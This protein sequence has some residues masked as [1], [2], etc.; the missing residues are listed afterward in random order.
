PGVSARPERR[1]PEILLCTEGS[2][3]LSAGGESLA[4]PRG[5]SVF[6]SAADGAYMLEGEGV[7]YRATAGL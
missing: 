4:L 2:A 5:A 1:G 7:V 3:R 6:V